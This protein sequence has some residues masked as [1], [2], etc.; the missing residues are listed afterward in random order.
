MIA[1]GDAIQGL[2][3]PRVGD[4]ETLREKMT[5]TQFHRLEAKFLRGQ[6]SLCRYGALR[7]YLSVRV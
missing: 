5:V 4:K 7:Y 3:N 6:G 2:P 1:L